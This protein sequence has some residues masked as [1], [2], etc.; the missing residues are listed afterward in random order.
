LLNDKSRKIASSKTWHSS[1]LLVTLCQKVKTED[2]ALLDNHS[3]SPSNAPPTVMLA[4]CILE[5]FSSIVSPDID[6]PLCFSAL[7]RA[8]NT[9]H[10]HFIPQ[11]FK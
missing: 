4:I 9:S 11:D 8:D 6:W 3:N 5:V 2:A 10:Y 1:T 7:L